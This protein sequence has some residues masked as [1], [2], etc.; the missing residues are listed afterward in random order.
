MLA[1]ISIPSLPGSNYKSLAKPKILTYS[2]DMKKLIEFLF[3]KGPK[4]F[5]SKGRV[6]HDHPKEKWDQWDQRYQMGT[7]YNWKTH[8]GMRGGNPKHP[9]S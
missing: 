6:F 2:A 1:L 4:I 3:G 5:D 8:V 9:Q 7:E